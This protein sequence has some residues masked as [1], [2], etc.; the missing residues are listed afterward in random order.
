MAQAIKINQCTKFNGM[1][2]ESRVYKDNRQHA[3]IS[4]ANR[5]KIAQIT[6]T[7]PLVVMPDKLMQRIIILPCEGSM[8]IQDKRPYGCNKHL[9]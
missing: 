6:E 2:N 9:K 7:T 5:P 8:I 1:V 3:K 4:S